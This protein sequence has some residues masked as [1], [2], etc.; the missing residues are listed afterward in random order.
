M[1]KTLIRRY[2][3]SD[4]PA[5]ARLFNERYGGFVGPIEVTADS[6]DRMY[7][8]GWW[9]CPSLEKDPDCVQVA[10]RSGKV[11][12]YVAFRCDAERNPGEGM[13]QELAV[14]RSEART[15]LD[16][17]L[18]AHAEAMMTER[19]A[20]RVTMLCHEDDVELWRLLDGTGYGSSARERTVFMLAVI[21]LAGLLERMAPLLERRLAASGIEP[22]PRG[23]V[24]RTPG[25]SARLTFEAGRVGVLP[26]EPGGGEGDR[27]GEAVFSLSDDALVGLVTGTAGADEAYLDGSGSMSVAPGP[28]GAGGA[29]DLLGA[30]FPRVPRAVVRAHT[31]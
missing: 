28:G 17:R 19:G 18:L 11:V 6:F 25:H 8:H 26:G 15:G 23:L 12:G 29:L 3:S 7:Q 16:E 14:A 21:D 30:L 4:A 20:V 31:W 10:E 22:P 27:G 1:S 13:V 24:L 2:A 5:V 9:N